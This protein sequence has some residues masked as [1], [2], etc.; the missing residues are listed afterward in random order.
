MNFQNGNEKPEIFLESL[1]I[2][3][4]CCSITVLLLYYRAQ[5]VSWQYFLKVVVL[6]FKLPF[7]VRYFSSHI[8]LADKGFAPSCHIF[9][10]WFYEVSLSREILSHIWSKILLQFILIPYCNK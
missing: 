2:F 7:P 5:S 6:L 4:N 9:D 10:P 8:L 1:L 3:V